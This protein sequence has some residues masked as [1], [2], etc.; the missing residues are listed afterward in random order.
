[1]NHFSRL[2]SRVMICCLAS[3]GAPA[4]ALVVAWSGIDSHTRVTPL[5]KQGV[6]LTFS[7][8]YGCHSLPAKTCL[9]PFCQL[10][11]DN[12]QVLLVLAVVM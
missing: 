4:M 12:Q 8:N 7:I 11:A 9:G 1:M 6:P 5:D 10:H 3:E 2:L